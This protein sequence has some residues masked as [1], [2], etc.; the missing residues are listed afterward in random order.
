MTVDHAIATENKPPVLIPV[1]AG[2]WSLHVDHSLADGPFPALCALPSGECPD[3]VRAV[4]SSVNTEVRQFSCAG[5]SYYL[6]EYFFL[7][8]KKHL[9]IAG[10]GEKLLRIAHQLGMAGFLTPR[11]V[12]TGK[13]GLTRRVVTEAVSGA[14]DI[15]QVLF[16]DMIH[17]RGK[18]DDDFSFAFGKIVGRF[19]SAGFSHGDLRWRNILT[20]R[21]AD[22]WAF[23]FIDNDRTSLHGRGIPFRCRVKN[24]TQVLF[25]GLLLNWPEHEW[26][27]FLRGYREDAKLSPDAW[28]NLISKVE[29]RAQKRLLER[30]DRPAR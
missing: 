26:Q 2:G 4:V 23:Y 16:P 15:W 5:Q 12:A 30:N 24:L 29:A 10:T 21:E 13:K 3:G 1:R 28:S 7:G 20:R 18:V 22:A 14:K 25:S 11:V 27:A 17:Y 19:H 9:R 8:W 6:K